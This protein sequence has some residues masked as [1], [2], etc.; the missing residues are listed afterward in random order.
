MPNFESRASC[1][2]SSRPYFLQT[3]CSTALAT[4]IHWILPIPLGPFRAKLGKS[5]KV[6]SSN[7]CSPGVPRPYGQQI[8]S[9]MAGPSYQLPDGDLP[10]MRS[11]IHHEDSW[12]AYLSLRHPMIQWPSSIDFKACLVEG[13]HLLLTVVH[14]LQ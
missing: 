12:D 11:K 4:G 3:A 13:V 7:K 9:W 6:R 5:G 8:S 10:A 14:S 2:P 1:G